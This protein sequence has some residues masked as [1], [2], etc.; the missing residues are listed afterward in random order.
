MSH[1][2]KILFKLNK[3][4]NHDQ[5][6]L[7]NQNAF[8]IEGGGT[9]GVYAIGVLKYL[10]ESNKY[11]NLN[12]VSIFGGTSV[13]SYL[14]TALSLGCQKEDLIQVSQVINIGELIDSKYIFLITLYR[15]LACGYLY[16]DSGRQD[17][18]WKILQCKM[19]AI[20]KHLE[21][22]DNN[23]ITGK[24]ITFG[25]LK[26]L[27]QKYPNIYKHLIINT[28]D[29]SKSE[30][31]FMTTLNDK[32]TNIKLADALLA[33]SAIPFV[34]KTTTL[35]YYPDSDTYGYA[36][37]DTS[38]INNFIDGGVSTNNPLDYFLLNNKEYSSYNLWLLK[39]TNHPQY[40]RIDNIITLLKQLSEYLITGKN[41]IK[42]D[43]VEE[44]Y[45]INT[46]N[47]NTKAGTLEIY[48]AEKIQEIIETIYNQCVAGIIHFDNN[49][50]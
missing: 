19:D 40:V 5:I 1:F 21:F 10:F 15:F 3:N 23:K 38:T 25:H 45:K 8:F 7:P 20:N 24:D 11:L 16:D 28:V 18:V 29:I 35:Y 14:A 27:I 48:S 12:S 33:S 50:R 44:E 34:F 39:F 46:I 26:I 17:I 30:Q 4:T 49:Q 31:I 47:L 32:W 2:L 6:M 37:T 43:L 9:K 36:Q 22:N 42:M 13:G 41:D